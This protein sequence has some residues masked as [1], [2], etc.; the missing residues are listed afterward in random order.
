MAKKTLM[1]EA[2]GLFSSWSDEIEERDGH[3][4]ERKRLRDKED[5]ELYEEIKKHNLDGFIVLCSI[6]STLSL[7][8]R[9]GNDYLN[10]SFTVKLYS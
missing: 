10:P 6:I 1:D 2:K 7:F 8:I 5:E 4:L 3:I 9:H